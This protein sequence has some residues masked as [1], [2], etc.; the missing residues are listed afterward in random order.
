MAILILLGLAV[1]GF[2]IAGA[3]VGFVALSKTGRVEGEVRDLKHRILNLTR[4]V[5]ELRQSAPGAKEEVTP[6]EPP[7][8][9]PKP[10][11]PAQKYAE[12][13]KP[14][15]EVKPV[16]PPPPLPRPGIDHRPLDAP[17]P[18]AP[19]TGEPRVDI[20]WGRI[21]EVVGKY[22]MLWGGVV[23]LFIGAALFLKYAF[24][25]D[26]IGPGG[27]VALAG[28][29]GIGVACLGQYMIRRGLDTFGQALFGCGLMI[30][31]VTLF[32]SFNKHVYEHPPIPNR[33]LVFS[34]MC[35]VTI[36][37]L[38]GSL[39]NNARA[40]M[41][42]ALIGGFMTPVLVSTGVDTRDS[43]FTYILMLD[44]GV[45]AIA[46]YKKWRILDVLAFFS[47]C[48]LFAGWFAQFYKPAAIVGTMVWLS[49][50]YV[51]FLV[52]PFVYHV[53][54]RTKVT[55]E[56][57]V[58]TIVNAAFYFGYC[59]Y[60]LSPEH[61]TLFAIITALM[62]V[63]YLLMGAL[64]MKR[65]Q[66][67]A[68]TLF[69]FIA[70]AVTCIATAIPLHFEMNGITIGWTVLGG[71]VVYL[72]YVFSYRPARTFGFAVL[73][74]AIGKVFVSHWPEAQQHDKSFTM[75]FNAKFLILMFAPVGAGIVAGIH[76]W[77]KEH[78][79][80][81][82]QVVK[83]VCA[84]GA[85]LLFLTFVD[86]EVG[87]WFVA[88]SGGVGPRAG[89]LSDC[90][91]AI[92]W[93]LGA[94]AFL[95]AGRRSKSRITGIVAGLPLL[96]ATVYVIGL[97]GSG[98]GRA[99]W[100]ILNARFWAAVVTLAA[101]VALVL[102]FAR[103][104]VRVSLLAVVGY[105]AVL[106]L[107]MEL[108][109]WVQHVSEH[110]SDATY[111]GMWSG[112]VMWTAG[113]LAGIAVAKFHRLKDLYW[114]AVPAFFFSALW[115]IALYVNKLPVDSMLVLNMRFVSGLVFCAGLFAF[116][117]V[118]LRNM[119][120]LGDG[121]QCLMGVIYWSALAALL[122][123]LSLEPHCWIHQFVPGKEANWL[124]RMS[125]TIVWALYGTAVLTMGFVKRERSLR[126][127][128]LGL[129]ALTSLKVVIIDL[130]GAEEVYRILSFVVLA[131]LM[132]GSAYAYNKAEVLLKATEAGDG[133]SE[134]KGDSDGE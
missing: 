81:I 11:A 72:G 67:D 10:I 127:A 100:I 111:L 35:V 29:A 9:V 40:I 20:A 46:F 132:I 124:A 105:A 61:K 27:Q 8:P 120:S 92:L 131:V 83:M 116:A 68:K 98:P 130:S 133:E 70:L 62:G 31:Y 39:Y 119:E 18:L 41:I 95:A 24:D 91:T 104:R 121:E 54:S 93:S 86:V 71:V 103:D 77:F 34:L 36:V 37:G 110:H 97:Y 6:A 94:A 58:M 60:I 50:F 122:I 114:A 26:W 109:R 44:L 17:R 1:V 43:L 76:H 25:R 82:D 5:E 28:I 89:Y 73:L 2:V 134:E 102:N 85:G 53:R 13:V 125:V 22:W 84:L 78:A 30:L 52:L 63:V 51:V 33:V 88:R 107:H 106:L 99:W 55:L 108:R 42:F 128:G 14:P 123:L 112:V 47:T 64:E 101:T 96:V 49:A 15:V 118:L 80:R 113:A 66:A 32:C 59:F 7:P 21:E 65:A 115:A 12:A 16:P 57:F 90:T 87:Q 129:L 45:L 19:V 3:I 4:T 75:F 23:L 126:L 79:D 69:A 38:A 117:V 56:R 74:F 48:I